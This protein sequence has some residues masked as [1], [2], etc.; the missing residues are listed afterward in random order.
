MDDD[1]D[2]YFLTSV[3]RQSMGV[4]DHFVPFPW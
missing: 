2:I 3:V 4:S 1:G